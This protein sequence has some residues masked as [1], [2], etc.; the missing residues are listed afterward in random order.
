M[1]EKLVDLNILVADDDP[2]SLE[3][4]CNILKDLGMKPDGVATGVEAV[5]YVT[6]RHQRNEDYFACIIDWK[7][8]D[9]DGIAVCKAIR[10][11][12]GDDVPIIIISAYDWSSIEAEAKA[13]G[14]NAFISKP[15][16]RSR[17]VNTFNRLA[18]EQEDKEFEEPLLALKNMNYHDKR[19]LLVEDNFLNAE[20]TKEILKTT[21]L[22]V[23]LATNGKQAVDKVASCYDG[24]Y[25]IIFMDIQMPVMNGYDATRA[26]RAMNREY[27][28]NV[29]IIAMTANAFQEDVIAAKA[30]GMNEHIAKPIDLK[31]FGKTLKIWLK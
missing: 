8:P 31:S 12:V 27:C 21:G 11:T 3:S 14:V 20:I 19:V 10:Q 18:D 4:C 15:F 1:N 23:E 5:E 22:S 2:S 28:K 26:I 30:A 7:M 6:V 16:F 17:L 25:D 29:P 13:A 24:Y 9:M